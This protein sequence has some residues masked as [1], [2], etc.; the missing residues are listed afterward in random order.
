[1]LHKASLALLVS[2]I[3]PGCTW[4]DDRDWLHHTIHLRRELPSPPQPLT[5]ATIR[6]RHEPETLN[7]T[8]ATLLA[9]ASP[10]S[11]TTPSLGT[12]LEGK[13]RPELQPLGGVLVRVN[14][15]PIL[16]EEVRSLARW[17][18]EEYLQ[19]HRPASFNDEAERLAIEAEVSRRLHEVLEQ[20][21]DRELLYQEAEKR[22]P[23]RGMELVR[24]AAQ[25]EIER[26]LLRR[27]QQMGFR[28]EDELREY[29]AQHRISLPTLRRQIER[30]LIAEEY[31][32]TLIRPK[33]EQIDRRQLWDYYQRHLDKFHRPEHVEWQYIFISA[34]EGARHLQPGEPPD[35]AKARAHAEFVYALAQQTKTAEEFSRL[36]EQYTDGPSRNGQGEGH[37]LNTIRPVE[38]AQLVWK[39]PPGQVGPLVAA[40]DGRG[41]HI[42]RVHK[43][44]PARTV[45]FDEACLEIRRQLQNEIFLAERERILRE[46]RAKAHIEYP[47]KSTPLR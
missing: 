42:F 16:E 34:R 14:G 38:I 35:P 19:R 7:E 13:T 44:E 33:F 22:V 31:L 37:D 6:G 39:T 36:A 4:G 32:R 3:I 26:Q 2:L 12:P 8:D 28:T 25:Q 10:P 5:T 11:P 41:Y 47:A 29:L 27:R 40:P 20:L 21:I 9:Q 24:K 45:P 15:E 43:H 30:N 17:M 23:P 46:L 1:M 18:L